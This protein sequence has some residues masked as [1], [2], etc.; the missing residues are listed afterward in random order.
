MN[1]GLLATFLAGALVAS[2]GMNIY[3]WQQSDIKQSAELGPGLRSPEVPLEDLE[4]NK[5]QLNALSRL[6]E[7]KAGAAAD[8]RQRIGERTQEL[9]EALQA[10]PIDE[11][12]VKALAEDLRQLRRE[13]VD[14]Q[15]GALLAVR[16][17]LTPYQTRLLYQVL[18]P[19]AEAS[20]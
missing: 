16:E 3:L 10:D 9:Q 2:A 18:Y 6:G 14:Q 7:E 20:R 1:S 5:V 11:D 4:L 17:L 8:L 19:E 12:R 15:V 13:E